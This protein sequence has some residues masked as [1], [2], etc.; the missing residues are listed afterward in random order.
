MEMMETTVVW[1]TL[2][3]VAVCVVFLAVKYRKSRSKW[4]LISAIR[5]MLVAALQM[6]LLAIRYSE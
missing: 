6:V 5:W 3:L 4:D 1:I 2:G